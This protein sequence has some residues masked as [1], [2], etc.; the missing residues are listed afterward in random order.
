MIQQ[1]KAL[2]AF[3]ED[4]GSIPSTQSLITTCKSSSKRS[5]TLV[6]APRPPHI[7]G[8][9]ICMQA[10]HPYAS[11]QNLKLKETIYYYVLNFCFLILHASQ[12]GI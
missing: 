2:A 7:H 9:Q 11:K 8:P 5:S 6:W 4:L 1:S 10:K 3:L 12:G